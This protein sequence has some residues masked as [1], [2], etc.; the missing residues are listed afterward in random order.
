MLGIAHLAGKHVRVTTVV[1]SVY[2][3]GTLVIDNPD[4]IEDNWVLI[5]DVEN[6]ISA[7]RRTAVLINPIHVVSIEVSE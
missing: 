2:Y 4:D 7:R 6:D 1:P 3:I 5:H